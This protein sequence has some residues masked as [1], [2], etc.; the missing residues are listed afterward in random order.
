[1]CINS[2]RGETITR[3]IINNIIKK[4]YSFGWSTNAKKE[5]KLDVSVI[6]YMNN[7]S[8]RKEIE[9]RVE[10]DNVKGTRR[11]GRMH[12]GSCR[13][14]WVVDNKRERTMLFIYFYFYFWKKRIMLIYNYEREI[15]YVKKK[16]I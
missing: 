1:M 3:L 5:R 11:T 13:I 8:Q 15:V 12:W 10:L 7:T 2:R 6:S 14:G 4:V 16:K 9:E